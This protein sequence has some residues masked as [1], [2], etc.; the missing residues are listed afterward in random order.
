MYAII[1]DGGRQ[2]RVEPGLEVDVDYRDLA[3]GE[4]IK[5]ERVLAISGDSGLRLGAPTV[6]GATVS[7]SVLGPIQDEKLYIQKFRRRKHS[8]RRSGHRQLHMRVRIEDIAG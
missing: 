7:G 2:Y 4:T 5:F 8:K 6:A 3:A 1:V